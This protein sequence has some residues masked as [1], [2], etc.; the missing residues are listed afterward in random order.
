MRHIAVWT[1]NNVRNLL[2]DALFLRH[3]V[4][5]HFLKTDQNSEDSNET[6]IRSE[7]SNHTLKTH[8][9]A[10]SIMRTWK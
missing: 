4:I 2:V 10:V 9:P 5:Y 7:D 6:L 1:Q 3:F 8:Y